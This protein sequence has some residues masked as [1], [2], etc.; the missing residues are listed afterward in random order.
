MDILLR[1]NLHS[2][3]KMQNS[4]Y[5]LS[6]QI[7]KRYTKHFKRCSGMLFCAKLYG[8]DLKILI[9]SFTLTPISIDVPISRLDDWKA[10]VDEQIIEDKE[11]Q[12]EQEQKEQRAANLKEQALYKKLKKKYEE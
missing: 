6:E 8:T 9:G 5:E 12:Y 4:L 10:W 3:R 11:S 7:Y 2:Y 1:D